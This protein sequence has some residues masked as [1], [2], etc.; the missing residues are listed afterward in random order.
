MNRHTHTAPSP[1]QQRKDALLVATILAAVGLY[2]A[3]TQVTA[4]PFIAAAAV[5]LAA[6]TTVAA[7]LA[8]A[9]AKD[10]LAAR[11]DPP[12]RGI[13]IGAVRGAYKL[14]RRRPYVL[15]WEC[16]RQ[17][18]LITGPTGR[19]KS[20][21]FIAPILRAHIHR[22]NTGVLYMDGKGDPIHQGN[23][24]VTFDH[25]FWPENPA[26]SACWNPLAGPDPFAAARSF[27]DAIFPTA[28][29]PGAV[30]YEVRGAFAIRAVL[31]AI[32]YTGL[33]LQAPPKTSEDEVRA[34]LIAAGLSESDATHA[35]TY[36]VGPCEDQLRW[37]STRKR[38]T[39]EALLDFIKNNNRPSP[40]MDQTLLM[41]RPATPTVAALHH[42]LF[43]DGQLDELAKRLDGQLDEHATDIARERFKMLA[44]QVRTLAALPAKERAGVLSNLENRIAVFLTPPFDRLCA[45]SDVTL[46][47]VCAGASIAMLLPV[48][49]FPGIAEPLGRVA[50]AQLQQ[51][52]LASTPDVTKVAVLDEFHNFVS[53]AFTKFLAQARSRGGAAVMSTQTIADFHTDYRDQLLASASTQIVTP[54]A[55]PYDA[56]HW[57]RAF[58]EQQVEQQSTTTAP[59]SI[60][61]P[62]PQPT[63]RRELRDAPRFTPT[64]VSELAPGQ[65]LIR[66]V[67]GRTTYPATIVDVERRNG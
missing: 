53:P 34:A 3:Y 9:R 29:Q 54:G 20:Y 66:Q 25:V 43:S 62:A 33:G 8:R 42:V 59:R 17:H 7:L 38:Q 63:I 19:G 37:L 1:E 10:A 48:G 36:G 13:I 16:F 28:G 52:V 24:A 22:P 67:S 51:A 31:P 21:G 11:K 5:T 23:E 12:R 56:E 60:L 35:L 2:I 65:A 40:N 44:A 58:G 15:T 27:A 41:P 55:M 30:Y 61:D 6:A 57:S 45:R 64:Q 39:P 4:H 32:A 50:L 18:V 49:T 26:H 47:N 14:A 46:A